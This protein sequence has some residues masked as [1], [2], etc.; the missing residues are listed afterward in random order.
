M[1]FAGVI[2]GAT[3]RPRQPWTKYIDERLSRGPVGYDR[4]LIDA[5]VLVSP[6]RGLRAAI[7]NRANVAAAKNRRAPTPPETP[8]QKADAIRAGQRHVVYQSLRSLVARGRV[9]VYV[10]DGV[11]MVALPESE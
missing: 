6:G 4:L 1:G 5:S 3:G 2:V 7:D 9:V 11:K 8:A 10:E